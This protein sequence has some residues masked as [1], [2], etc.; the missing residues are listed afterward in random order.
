VVTDE[1]VTTRRHLPSIGLWF[2]RSLYDSPAYCR[3]S[4]FSCKVLF[5]TTSAFAVSEN[6][7]RP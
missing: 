5:S 3:E 2:F 7:H 1:Y 6:T 4:T